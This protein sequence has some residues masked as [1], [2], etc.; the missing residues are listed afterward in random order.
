MQQSTFN[1]V[2]TKENRRDHNK[3]LFNE[4]G[5]VVAEKTNAEKRNYTM[6]T[7]QCMVSS[8]RHGFCYMPVISAQSE[9]LDEI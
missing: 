9:I 6:E 4:P 5:V 3:L 7:F 2:W 1:M 8:Q